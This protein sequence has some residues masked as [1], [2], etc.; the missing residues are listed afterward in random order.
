MGLKTGLAP[1][2]A[3]SLLAA[4]QVLADSI[5]P[6]PLATYAADN[7]TVAPPYRWSLYATIAT[8]GFVT[9]RYCRGYEDTEPFC[10]TAADSAPNG[11]AGAILA[12][13]GQAGLAT[14]PPQAEPDEQHVG[15]GA[16]S[17]SVLLN[18]GVVQLPSFPV[19]QDQARV[20]AVLTAVAAAIPADLLADAEGRAV[21]PE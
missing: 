1:W 14:R 12:A 8:D 17:G 19:P 4:P 9:L 6:L 3:T 11:A 20:A 13:A 2:I 10:A 18:G 16:P 5:T 21:P 15:G 7:G